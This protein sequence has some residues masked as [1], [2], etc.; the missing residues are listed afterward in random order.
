MVFVEKWTF[1]FSVCIKMWVE[2]SGADGSEKYSLQVQLFR[3]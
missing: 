3:A 2:L 1:V